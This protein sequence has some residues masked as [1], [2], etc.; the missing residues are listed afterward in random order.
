VTEW[1]RW[2]KIH[3][4]LEPVPLPRTALHFHTQESLNA[5]VKHLNVMILELSG[6]M[7]L[8]SELMLIFPI[9]DIVCDEDHRIVLF[10]W[11][12]QVGIV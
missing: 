1:L 10:S 7:L 4:F 9:E 3:P 6:L 12:P 8:N 5:V 2:G 11:L